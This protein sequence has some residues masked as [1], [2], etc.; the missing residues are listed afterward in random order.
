VKH[1]ASAAFVFLI[2]FLIWEFRIEL[3]YHQPQSQITFVP[4]D[5]ILTPQQG[6]SPRKCCTLNLSV[7][8]PLAM[9]FIEE[10]D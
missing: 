3:D 2:T 6:E 9:A 4:D 7:A 1:P 10:S 5:S 8:C